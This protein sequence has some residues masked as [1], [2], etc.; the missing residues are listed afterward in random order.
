MVG[1]KYDRATT[2][3]IDSAGP[4]AA[5]RPLATVAV[6]SEKG[7]PFFGAQVIAWLRDALGRSRLKQ[8]LPGLE[9][10][11]ISP[12]ENVIALFYSELR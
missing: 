9:S 10:L 8:I 3:G 2:D 12:R 1:G 4:E 7:F 11:S 5:T 6:T